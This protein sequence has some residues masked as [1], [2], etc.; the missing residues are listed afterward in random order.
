MNPINNAVPTHVTANHEQTPTPNQIAALRD[1]N[2]SQTPAVEHL[3]QNVEKSGE[4][5]SN[6]VDVYA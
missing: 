1:A 2:Q 4:S 5:Q 3:V 6:H